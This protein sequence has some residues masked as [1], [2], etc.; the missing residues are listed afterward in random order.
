ML[1]AGSLVELLHDIFVKLH[2]F[3]GYEF[4]LH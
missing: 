4:E 1:G 3:Q 2:F